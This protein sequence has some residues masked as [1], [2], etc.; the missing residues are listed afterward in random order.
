MRPSIIL[1]TAAWLLATILSPSASLATEDPLGSRV[2]WIASRMEA[3]SPPGRSLFKD[4]VETPEQGRE[5]YAQIAASIARVVYDPSEPPVFGGD[6]GRLRTAALVTSVLWFE[7]GFRRDVDLGRGPLGRGDGGRS[8]CMAQAN[9]GVPGPSGNS[10]NRIVMGPDGGLSYSNDPSVGH[11]GLDLVS[12]RDLCVR[13]AMRRIRVAFSS[14][15]GL[16]PADRMS[17]YVS[18]S[19]RKG[20]AQS[21]ARYS[22]ASRWLGLGRPKFSDSEV[23]SFLAARH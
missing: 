10:P 19:C 22:R 2:S 17:Q 4:A 5:R 6:D 7:S 23:V 15:R 16:E 21:R 14:C 12:D 18:G 8:W 9:L 11:G 20:M 13:F 1:L 3:W